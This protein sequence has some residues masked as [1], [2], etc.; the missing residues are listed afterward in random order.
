MSTYAQ[1]FTLLIALAIAYAAWSI[2][3]FKTAGRPPLPPGPKGFPLLGNINDL[4]PPGELEARHWLKHKRLY[5]A[6][7][8]LTLPS[9][10][11]REQYRGPE[12][13]ATSLTPWYTRPDK[14]CDGAESNFHHHK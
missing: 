5:G 7:F 1:G 6:C 9:V 11:S 10:L 13:N 4:P 8:S 12:Q 3:G 2:L 14:L